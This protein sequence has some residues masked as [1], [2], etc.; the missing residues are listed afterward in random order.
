MSRDGSLDKLLKQRSF[1]SVWPQRVVM[2]R[3]MAKYEFHAEFPL[4]LS[5]CEPKKL[6]EVL[7]MADEQCQQK[8][9]LPFSKFTP[10]LALNVSTIA[11]PI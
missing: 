9:F 8:Y 11:V 3:F 6:K 1:T 4:C 7:A 2:Q 5:D 10:I